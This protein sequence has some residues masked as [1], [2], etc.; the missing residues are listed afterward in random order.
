MPNCMRQLSKKFLLLPT[1]G[2]C[3]RCMSARVV[4][5]LSHASGAPG[6][7]QEDHSRLAQLR[8][9]TARQGHIY[10]KF[11]WCGRRSRGTPK[12]CQPCPLSHASAY[13]NLIILI[14]CHML[15]AYALVFQLVVVFWCDLQ[16]LADCCCPC[17]W[18]PS[19]QGQPQEPGGHAQGQGGGCAR[20]AAAVLQVRGLVPQQTHF[21]TRVASAILCRALF[22]SWPNNPLHHVPST[23]KCV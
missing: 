5:R 13:Q 16:Y 21:G 23:C 17:N 12:R 14:T 18:V 19:A 1:S 8:A 2:G 3:M 6:V 4:T 10:R 7:Q 9:H 22:M 20:G 15:F 11:S